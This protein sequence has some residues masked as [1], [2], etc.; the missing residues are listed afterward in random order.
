MS[1]SWLGFEMPETGGGFGRGQVERQ[2]NQ[3]VVPRKRR[4]RDDNSEFVDST[5]NH[6]AGKIAEPRV[7]DAAC[8][9]QRWLEGHPSA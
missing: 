8:S 7:D 1:K 3:Y 4:S 5:S 6:G 9:Q 2:E